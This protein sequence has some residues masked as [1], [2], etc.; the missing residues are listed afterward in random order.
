MDGAEHLADKLVTRDRE[1]DGRRVCLECLHLGGNR[2]GS[3][4]CRGWKLAGIA[5]SSRD[6]QLPGDIVQ[7]LQRCDGFIADGFPAVEVEKGKP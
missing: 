4:A 1:N 5:I 3:W 6:A 7:L 2:A